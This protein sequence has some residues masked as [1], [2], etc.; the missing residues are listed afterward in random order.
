[1]HNKFKPLIGIIIILLFA[2]LALA[3]EQNPTITLGWDQ[4]DETY[5]VLTRWQLGYG[6][7]A[8]GPYDQF[9]DIPKVNPQPDGSYQSA[10][11][12]TYSGSP[13][14]VV[15]KYFILRACISANDGECSAWSANE[16]SHAVT[17][18]IGAP[19]NFRKVSATVSILINSIIRETIS[20]IEDDGQP[21]GG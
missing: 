4:D 6:S 8:G 15:T 21:A 13:G 1:M 20:A 19:G 3:A 14:E 11:E 12:I 9:V 18:P 16:V 5:A 17:I 2:G 10:T 7:T